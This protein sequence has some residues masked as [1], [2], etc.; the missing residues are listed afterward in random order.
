MQM[1]LSP[2]PGGVKWAPSSTKKR[3]PIESG[4]SSGEYW[5]AKLEALRDEAI[6]NFD[7]ELSNL[8]Y[9]VPISASLQS[10][11]NLYGSA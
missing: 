10:L 4:I 6:E 5:V 11:E 8:Q 7:I 9:G 1:S 2:S 3:K